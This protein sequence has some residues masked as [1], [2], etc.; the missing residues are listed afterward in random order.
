MTAI[1][2]CKCTNID[3][4]VFTCKTL[5]LQVVMNDCENAFLWR[6]PRSSSGGRGAV[7]DQWPSAVEVILP[8]LA[9]CLNRSCFHRAVRWSE[10]SHCSEMTPSEIIDGRPDPILYEEINCN[11]S[12]S[13]QSQ[14][15][16]YIFTYLH[17]YIH[18]YKSFDH[19]L[20]CT[21]YAHMFVF[22]NCGDNP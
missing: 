21:T 7:E 8:W 20:S 4:C 16:I 5:T 13:K 19:V 9:G 12:C 11:G 15:H 14:V 3:L 17:K 10:R 18:K 2:A 1:C 22:I 6:A